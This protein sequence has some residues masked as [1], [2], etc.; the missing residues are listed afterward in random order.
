MKRFNKIATSLAVVSALSFGM[1][2]CG[3]SSSSNNVSSDLDHYV[4]MVSRGD[5]YGSEVKDSA[6]P[7]HKAVEIEGTNKYE[8]NVP[9]GDIVF[10]LIATGGYID[11]DGNG[12]I[13]VGTDVKLDVDLKSYSDTLTPVTTYAV[14]ELD[15]KLNATSTEIDAKLQELADA[16]N[17][18]S[19]TSVDVTISD[20]VK[21]ASETTVEAQLAINSVYAELHE[22][23]NNAG[24]SFSLDD[25][26]ATF[27][28]LEAKDFGS[29]STKEMSVKI[30][31]TLVT[32]LKIDTLSADDIDAY[33][34]KMEDLFGDTSLD[35]DS[36]TSV[37]DL[38]GK[39]LYTIDKDATPATYSKIEL[40][41][42]LDSSSTK[43][44]TT[45]YE[46]NDGEWKEVT[47]SDLAAT[48]T[49]NGS[50]LTLLIND[51]EQEIKN[52]IDEISLTG[53]ALK[54]DLS[55]K[56]LTSQVSMDAGFSAEVEGE[57]Y[58]EMTA[59]ME[60]PSNI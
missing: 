20:L 9:A 30:E 21:P 37:S 23:S 32:D 48:A 10:P 18:A 11:V 25:V 41:D 15:G 57:I 42:S 7:A 56:D 28:D 53:S 47:D 6:T 36:L 33:K 35:L 22:N 34:S 46:L 31:E 45:T 55:L 58:L 38:Q 4:A 8:F 39:T 5:V 51:G 54:T 43:L 29:L 52:V 44:K 2:G 12:K 24:G 26:K 14:D 40:A 50:E 1:T 49:L 13:E 27:D 59:D 60:N 3:G 17:E 16:I 19:E